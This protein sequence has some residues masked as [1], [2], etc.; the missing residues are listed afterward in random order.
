MRTSRGLPWWAGRSLLVPAAVLLAWWMGSAVAS[1]GRQ[2]GAALGIAGLGLLLPV[3]TL[4]ARRLRYGFLTAELPIILLLVSNITLRIRSTQEL[5]AN[6]LDTAGLFRVACI[7]LAGFLGFAALLSSRASAGGRL[8]SLP[9]RLYIGYVL[10]VFAGAP[11]SA[12]PLLT[13]YRGVELA[14]A[15][16]ILLGARKTLGE[17]AT[18]RIESTLYWCTVAL[19]GSVWLGVALVPSKAIAS[20]ADQSIPIPYNL[21][22]VFPAISSNAVGTLGVVLAFWSLARDRSSRPG[23]L[24]PRLAYMMAA[25]G[26]VTLLLAQYRTGYVAAMISTVALLLIRRRWNL[27]VLVLLTTVT[28]VL[29]QPSLVADAEP[30]LLRGQTVTQAQE[31]SGRVTWWQAALPVWEESP[32]IGR[33]LLTASRFDVFA[34]MGADELAGLHSTWIEALLGTGLVGLALLALSFFVTFWRALREALAPDG[35]VVPVLLL[36]ILGVRS[37]TGNTFESFQYE[38]L[39]FLWLAWAMRDASPL[40]TGAG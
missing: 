38:A 31:L 39:V 22:G 8:T 35:W 27:A 23:R 10:V 3:A 36:G 19:V 34:Q 2:R 5:A 26:L 9:L 24:R 6:P 25:L 37:V 17:A 32:L 4:A 21:Q 1:G 30:Y 33:G 40:G 12:N 29:W 20:L 15:L 28:V 7:G 16:L 14:A 18:S 13:A 11:L